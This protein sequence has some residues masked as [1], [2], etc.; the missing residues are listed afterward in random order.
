VVAFPIGSETL[1]NRPAAAYTTG[2]GIGALTV[3]AGQV[4]EGIRVQNINSDRCANYAFPASPDGRFPV[5][6]ADCN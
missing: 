5:L 2:S 6:E 1:A 3:V 4:L